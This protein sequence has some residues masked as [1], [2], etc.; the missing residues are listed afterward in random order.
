MPADVPAAEGA[1][2]ADTGTVEAVDVVNS[3]LA[4]HI[5][6]MDHVGIAVRDLDAAKR[7]YATTLGFPCV[8]E[9]INE[10]QGIREA[11]VAVG[12]T[13]SFVQLL[14]PLS[15]DSTIGKFLDRKGPGIQQVAYR[16]RD[17]DGLTEHLRD[18]GV[19]LLY[20][21]GKRGTAGSRMNFIHPRDAGGVLI[22][23]VEPPPG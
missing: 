17:L 5:V 10:E 22:E 18:A 4:E 8:H 6:A 3:H 15:D 14:A 2:G 19:N 1:E 21:S 16:V 20:E 11:M 13:G 12:D 9:E 7:W 23:L